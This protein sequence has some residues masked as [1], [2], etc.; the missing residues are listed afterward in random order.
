MITAKEMNKI[1]IEVNE[2]EDI[3]RNMEE[4][5]IAKAQEGYSF[6]PFPDVIEMS[7]VR[8]DTIES[9]F[10]KQGFDVGV[11]FHSKKEYRDFCVSW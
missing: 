3:I 5:I 8:I 1:C 10:K 2:C 9:Y 4:A 7:R 11:T 6:K